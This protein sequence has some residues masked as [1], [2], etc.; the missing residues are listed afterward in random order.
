MKTEAQIEE[1][2]RKFDPSADNYSGMSYEQGV[3]E[4][5]QWVLGE[6]PD[7]EFCED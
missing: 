5:L 2:L 7:D 3:E 4:A 6:I 1:F